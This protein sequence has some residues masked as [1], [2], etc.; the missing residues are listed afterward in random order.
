[1]RRALILSLLF[2]S[3]ALHA[4]ETSGT[5]NNIANI[6]TDIYSIL[7]FLN[8]TYIHNSR[9]ESLGGLENLPSYAYS[10]LIALSPLFDSS[11]DGSISGVSST[12]DFSATLN[13][14]PVYD[15][16]DCEGTAKTADWFTAMLYQS[17]YNNSALATLGTSLDNIA[18]HNEPLIDYFLDWTDSDN[19]TF[20]YLQYDIFTYADLI[21][22]IFN[23]TGFGFDDSYYLGLSSSGE[24]LDRTLYAWGNNNY[25]DF[26]MNGFWNTQDLLCDL[27]SNLSTFGN[28][29]E[30]LA[31]SGDGLSFLGSSFD[32]EYA[33]IGFASNSVPQEVSLDYDE[34]DFFHAT[35]KLLSDGNKIDSSITYFL[36]HINDK[37][38]KIK[39]TS[40]DE[41]RLQSQI[42]SA[43]DVKDSLD[44]AFTFSTVEFRDVDD[45]F[46][47]TVL[48]GQLDGS[49]LPSSLS[50]TLPS[51]GSFGAHSF[52]IETD[53]LVP[54]LNV[55][56]AVFTLLYFVLLAGFVW[57]LFR[58]FFPL[59][60][61]FSTLLRSVLNW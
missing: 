35:V 32:H 37:M 25:F 59:L 43:S 57:Y 50:F 56:R 11:S 52:V 33:S 8:D 31:P 40:E 49:L 51:F 2:L 20:D 9:G 16:S 26:V 48:L 47:S 19:G 54:F 1:M 46:D 39:D 14:I 41:Q 55:S 53:S 22:Y 61:R 7:G 5:A 44:S 38:P 30:P 6:R 17:M 4:D 3:S 12:D 28:F 27:N 60:V 42:S 23:S 15:D 58:V 24:L 29:F 21:D 13:T 34:T 10:L 18:D 45:Y 36:K